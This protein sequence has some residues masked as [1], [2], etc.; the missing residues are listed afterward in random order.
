MSRIVKIICN[1][2][3]Q[4]RFINI[5][6]EDFIRQIV[7]LLDIC[8]KNIV[9]ENDYQLAVNLYQ[10]KIDDDLTIDLWLFIQYPRAITSTLIY[11]CHIS[12]VKIVDI[13]D[14]LM[15]GTHD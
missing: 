1:L 9:N 15:K 12:H 6:A 5:G 10:Y 8:L 14:L 3:Y 13:Y 11:L 4:P 2:T 7:K